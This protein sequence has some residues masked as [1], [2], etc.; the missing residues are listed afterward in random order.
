MSDIEK[1][2]KELEGLYLC[3]TAMQI[4]VRCFKRIVTKQPDCSAPERWIT[5]PVTVGGKKVDQQMV[6]RMLLAGKK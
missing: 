5:V 2:I 1:R 4:G 6:D 3:F